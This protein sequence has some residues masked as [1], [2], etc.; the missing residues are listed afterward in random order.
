MKLSYKNRVGYRK[1]SWSNLYYP[2]VSWL[3]IISL[4]L[5]TVAERLFPLFR[6]PIN[7]AM[8]ASGLF[9][10]VYCIGSLRKEYQEDKILN[11]TTC[12]YILMYIAAIFILHYLCNS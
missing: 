6:Q 5:S 7:T 9:L 10:A 8:H 12:I 4:L 2:V 11:I 1:E 3:F